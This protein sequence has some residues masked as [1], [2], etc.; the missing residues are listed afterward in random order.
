MIVNHILIYI[1]TYF[2]NKFILLYLLQKHVNENIIHVYLELVYDIWLI[3]P[4]LVMM[5]TRSDIQVQITTRYERDGIP[6]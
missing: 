6:L 1:C 3:F 2:A 5:H 4:S